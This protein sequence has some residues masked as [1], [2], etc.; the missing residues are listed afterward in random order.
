MIASDTT[1]FCA[2]ASVQLLADVI[3]GATY[4]WTLDGLDIAGATGTDIIT[5]DGGTYAVVVTGANGCVAVPSNSILV[6]VNALPA[7]PVITASL[8]TLFSSGN[9]TF[10]WYLGGTEIV[11]AT[12]SSLVASISGDYM[13]TI[14]DANGCSSTSAIYTYIS[15]GSMEAHMTGLYVYPNPNEGLFTIQNDALDEC[16]YTVTEMTGKLV[17]EGR[18]MNTRT[19]LNL[20]NQASG[21]YMLQVQGVGVSF[22]ERIV[23]R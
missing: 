4:Q 12:N 22:R 10:Q 21:I 19:T 14:T 18:L 13:V 5:S 8:D 9:G 2:G 16:T 15:T 17:Q 1:T 11:G 7:I 6:T 20:G 3:V 23:V